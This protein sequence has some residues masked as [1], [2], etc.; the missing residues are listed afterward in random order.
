[1]EGPGPSLRSPTVVGPERGP[2]LCF[3]GRVSLAPSASPLV[4]QLVTDVGVAVP[5]V[6]SAP[7]TFGASSLASVSQQTATVCGSLVFHNGALAVDVAYVSPGTSATTPG[8]SP[9]AL[10]MLALLGLLPAAG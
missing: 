2:I 10:V 5:L 4:G 3:V 1:M 9:L 7:V 6:Q 8:V